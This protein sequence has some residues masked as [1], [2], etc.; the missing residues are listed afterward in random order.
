MIKRHVQQSLHLIVINHHQSQFFRLP[1]GVLEVVPM[2]LNWTVL[3]SLPKFQLV[4][5]AAYQG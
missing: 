3:T 5:L 1:E 2:M 4:P